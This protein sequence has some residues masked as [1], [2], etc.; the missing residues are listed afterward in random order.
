MG[1]Q[2]NAATKKGPPFPDQVGVNPAAQKQ[3]IARLAGNEPLSKLAL[4]VPH[5]S[6]GD[7]L[8]KILLEANVPVLRATWYISILKVFSVKVYIYYFFVDFD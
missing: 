5:T 1:A 4:Q 2:G 3:W 7:P 8:L 6:K